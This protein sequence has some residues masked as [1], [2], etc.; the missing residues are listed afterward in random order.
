M[1]N[2]RDKEGV[3]MEEKDQ[4]A[5]DNTGVEP[6]G[7]EVDLNALFPGKG[8]DLNRLFPDEGTKKLLHDLK[9]NKRDIERFI[10]NLEV[11]ED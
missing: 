9:R 1:S 10:K 2:I 6:K 11:E 4:P 8:F 3:C 5:E 7:K